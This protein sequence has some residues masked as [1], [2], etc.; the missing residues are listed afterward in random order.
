[1]HYT[2]ELEVGIYAGKYFKE[3]D[4]IETCIGVITPQ[5]SVLET[6][7][8]EWNAWNEQDDKGFPDLI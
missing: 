8:G 3:E 4:L 5:S 6:V 1:M 7:A 2:E